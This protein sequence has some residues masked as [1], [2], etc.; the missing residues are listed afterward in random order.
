MYRE[1][2][3]FDDKQ[4]FL[5]DTS[6]F[7]VYIPTVGERLDYKIILESYFKYLNGSCYTG[8]ILGT[9]F[10]V[11]NELLELVDSCIPSVEY[12]FNRASM[13]YTFA[14]NSILYFGVMDPDKSKDHFQYVAMNLQFIGIVDYREYKIKQLDYLMCRLR[15]L[16]TSSIPLRYRCI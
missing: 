7:S 3:K 6:F 4:K 2:I 10:R 15:K 12:K 8:L 1:F 14:N 11:I 9:H 13:K 5:E 16:K